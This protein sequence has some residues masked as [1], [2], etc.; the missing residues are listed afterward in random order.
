MDPVLQQL[1]DE[2]EIRKLVIGFSLGMDSRDVDL[3]RASWAEEIE[4][5]LPPLAPEVLPFSGRQR[6][7]NYAKDVIGLLSEF[8]ATQHVSTNHMIA[9]SG[10]SA[11]CTCYTLAHHD[12]P[13]ESG[14]RWLSAGARY[15]LL[16]QRVDGLG[17]RFIRFKLT[18]L[19]FQGN[20]LLWQEAARRV[21]DRRHVKGPPLGC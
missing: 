3:F 19:W 1:H 21:I 13:V 7:D 17:W 11:T 10:D 12:L 9:V 4:L 14:E 20:R 5:D 16:A 15:D 6:A 18:D 8:R 2:N